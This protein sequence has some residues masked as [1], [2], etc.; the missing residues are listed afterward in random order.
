MCMENDANTFCNNFWF[1][2]DL[3]NNFWFGYDLIE[4]YYFLRI[5][6]IDVI[7]FFV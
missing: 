7:D 6:I 1:G 2:H 4:L 5:L 3:C